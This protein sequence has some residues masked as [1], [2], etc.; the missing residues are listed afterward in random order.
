MPARIMVLLAEM[1][2]SQ[3]N[4]KEKRKLGTR[5]PYLTYVLHLELRHTVGLLGYLH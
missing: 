2:T 5:V 3:S 1:R 4:R